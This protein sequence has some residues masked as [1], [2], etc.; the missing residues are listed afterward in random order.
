LSTVAAAAAEIKPAGT[1]QAAATTPQSALAPSHKYHIEQSASSD[2]MT[3]TVLVADVPQQGASVGIRKPP[4]G[5]GW[6]K[7]QQ[8]VLEAQPAG[9]RDADSFVGDKVLNVPSIIQQ[10]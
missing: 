7:V 3:G 5:G 6:K 8:V 4:A 9:D 2:A 10:Q 1:A